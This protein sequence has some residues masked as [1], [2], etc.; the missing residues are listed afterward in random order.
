MTNV[1]VLSLN[2]FLTKKLV[3]FCQEKKIK[4]NFAFITTDKSA[5]K[6][7]V[8]SYENLRKVAY[9]MSKGFIIN[10]AGINVFK[11]LFSPYPM[12]IKNYLIW[13][14]RIDFTRKLINI[15]GPKAHDFVFVIPSA[16]WIYSKYLEKYFSEWENVV[17]PYNHL[18]FRLGIVL[19]HDSQWVQII[20][21][22]LKNGIFPY[23]PKSFVFPFICVNEFLNLLVNSLTNFS[24]SSVFDCYKLTYF[25]DF[26]SLVKE[27]HGYQKIRFS[28]NPWI[29]NLFLKLFFGN[30][31]KVF[32]SMNLNTKNYVGIEE[33]KK[34]FISQQK[35]N[36]NITRY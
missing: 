6:E 20:G 24:N 30:Y 32:D 21:N 5:I 7:N 22:A 13:K 8:Y 10:F 19:S 1:I 3:S 14:S 4:F 12:F 26:I 27:I 34:C 23:F 25:N 35:M 9:E 11:T 36:T 28:I 2:S 16:V 33:V 17:K 29:T 15:L 31:G 18:I